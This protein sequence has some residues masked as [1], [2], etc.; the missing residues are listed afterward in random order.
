M[1]EPPLAT[2]SCVDV[3]PV[4]FPLSRSLPVSGQGGASFPVPLR[5]HALDDGW[6]GLFSPG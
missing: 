2:L 5:G 6:S 3:T 1:F 4:E